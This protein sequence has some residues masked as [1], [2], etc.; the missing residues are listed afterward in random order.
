MELDVADLSSKKLR[1]L[2]EAMMEARN[3]GL[4]VSALIVPPKV[5]F[6]P[7][8]KPRSDP[9]KAAYE[10]EAYELFYGGSAGGGKSDLLLGIGFTQGYKSIIF[11]TEYP[12]LKDIID[13]SKEIVGQPQ[14]GKYNAN[15][16]I[17]KLSKKY[18]NRVIEFGAVQ[19]ED[20]VRKYQGRPHDKKMYDELSNFSETKYRFLNGWLRSA[21]GYKPRIVAG[22]NPP[23]NEEGYWV[24]KRFAP[25]LDVQHPN[26]AIPTELRWFIVAD[27]EDRE[28]E[29]SAPVKF[30]T[31]LLMPTSRTFVPARVQ[32]NPF[33]AD[34]VYER[35]LQALPEPL[36]TQMLFGDF[37]AG[38]DANPW[39]CIPT[40]W[41]RA[42]QK[43]WTETGR[44]SHPKPTCV[45][46]DVARSGRDKTILA[47]RYGNWYAQLQKF[48]GSDTPDGDSVA[49]LVLQAIGPALDTTINIDGIGVG[50]AVYDA[51]K[52]VGTNA[53]S[54][55][56][57]Q[58]AKGEF[59]KSGKLSF[60]NLRAL[61][62]WR[63]REALDPVYGQGISLPPDPELLADLSSPQWK[64][65]ASGIQLES[66][67]DI[68]A[69]IG[70]S[71]DAGDAV[72]LA[73][74]GIYR[75]PLISFV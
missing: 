61:A 6:S 30:K 8:W 11:R 28:V 51:C 17:W 16:R 71:P 50:A 22:G 53:R 2:A 37:T 25:W 64:I 46:V 26:P 68:K 65:T 18:G 13:R 36:R 20:D 60:K 52:R 15:D 62:Y 58:S 39:Q 9:Q 69:R 54:I 31:E 49:G 24:I 48:R 70:R 67:D 73:N 5:E 14:N 7:L 34:G 38:H 27:G 35:T 72:V 44:D 59:D 19:Y 42:A 4:D 3:R 75:K 57:S 32:D 74:Y 66:K 43:R 55:I 29:D 21:A 12:Q 23:T 41:I 1:Q 56:F 45:G 33:F 40:E 10:S 47:L 63:F